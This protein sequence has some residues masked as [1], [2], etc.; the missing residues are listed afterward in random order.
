LRN[1]VVH[2]EAGAADD[3]LLVRFYGEILGWS[4]R[5]RPA[6]VTR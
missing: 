5:G 3:G 1:A 6:A 2:F 4:L